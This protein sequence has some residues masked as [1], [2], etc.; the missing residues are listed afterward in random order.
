M[1]LF[2]EIPRFCMT[3]SY[4]RGIINGGKEARESGKRFPTPPGFRRYIIEQ[5]R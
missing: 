2:G 1:L 4:K 5:D 3:N